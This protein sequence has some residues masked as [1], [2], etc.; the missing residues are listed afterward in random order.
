MEAL[1]TVKQPRFFND[2]SLESSDVKYRAGLCEKLRKSTLDLTEPKPRYQ[3]LPWTQMAA[4]VSLS[5]PE[6]L[7]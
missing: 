5:P 1:V 6:T 2:Y 3:M 7:L 4:L